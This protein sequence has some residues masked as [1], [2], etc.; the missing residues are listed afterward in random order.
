MLTYFWTAILLQWNPASLFRCYFLLS[1]FS[2]DEL[3]KT[4]KHCLGKPPH[5]IH[6]SCFKIL[7]S[8][9]SIWV[10]PNQRLSSSSTIAVS[11]CMSNGWSWHLDEDEDVH[12]EYAHQVYVVTSFEEDSKNKT[13]TTVFWILKQ[14]RC[15]TLKTIADGYTRKRGT[16]HVKGLHDF[17]VLEPRIWV[18]SALTE[19]KLMVNR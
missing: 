9:N 14:W 13:G 12:L 3:P 17:C 5:F 7:T 15:D 2:V 1:T 6:P 4:S 19:Q 10:L 11:L 18:L 16:T 8:Q